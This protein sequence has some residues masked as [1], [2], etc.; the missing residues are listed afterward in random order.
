V[1]YDDYP[2]L[3]VT[4]DNGVGILALNQPERLN[5]IS[6]STTEIQ[7]RDCLR[8][9]EN[10]TAVRVVV[11]TGN[12]RAFS[13][14]ADQ[15]GR[16]A[17]DPD[18]RLRGQEG[19][20]SQV[21]RFLFGPIPGGPS[22]ADG[23]MWLYLH[24]FRKPLI[25]AV[26][27]YALGG[28]WELAEAADMVIAGESARFGTIEIKLGTFPFGLGSQ[29]LAKTVGKH[30]ALELM[31]TGELIDAETACKWGLVNQV[32]SDDECLPTAVALAHQ[33]V[34]HA[35]LALGVTK[36]MVNKALSIDEHYDL[37]RALAYHLGRTEDTP[38]AR[39]AWRNKTG[40][41]DFKNR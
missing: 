12:G 34:G 36:Y 7:I 6:P 10:D 26:R 37:E 39:D 20:G 40:T 3:E 5:P 35:P 27:G 18:P 30:R 32:V 4:F 28:G 41:P 9:M 25:A 23:S 1:P 2:L 21:G 11:F 13:A 15:G 38:K 29:Y 22:I 33:L 8:E 24:K 19:S 17:P 14:G 16:G 31:M